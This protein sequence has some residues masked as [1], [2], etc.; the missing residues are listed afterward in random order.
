MAAG[1]NCSAMTRTAPAPG[2]SVSICSRSRPPLGRRLLARYSARPGGA[3]N[4]GDG[5]QARNQSSGGGDVR[6]HIAKE[7]SV[8][9]LLGFVGATIG[10]TVGWWLG[11]HIGITTAVMVSALGTGLG[12]WA[13]VR[14]ATDYLG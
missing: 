8:K 9:R 1:S 10:S 12:L 2:K 5:G 13:G 6:P 3:G 7:H 4:G 14:I 11:A